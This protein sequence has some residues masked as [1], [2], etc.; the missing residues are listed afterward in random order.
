MVAEHFDAPALLKEVL[1]AGARKGLK[2]A[3]RKA[4]AAYLERRATT[5]LTDWLAT[6]PA[7]ASVKLEPRGVELG[8][9]SSRDVVATFD[10]FVGPAPP[11]LVEVHARRGKKKK[12]PWKVWDVRCGAAGVHLSRQYA[13][14]FRALRRQGGLPALV[15]TARELLAR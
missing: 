6:L 12:A 1:G 10:L 13:A 7:D 3:D 4:L 14:Q 2:K 15:A 8:R 5:R 11:V 9:E